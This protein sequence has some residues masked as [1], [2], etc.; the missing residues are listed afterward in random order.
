[1]KNILWIVFVLAGIVGGFL[2]GSAVT[3]RKSTVHVEVQPKPSVVKDD[4]PLADA[5]KR[6]KELERELASVRRDLAKRMKSEAKIAQKAESNDVLSSVSNSTDV[7]MVGPDG[8]ILEGLKGKLSKDE[9]SQVTNAFA[10]MRARIAQRAKGRQEYLAA[11]DV[12]G[13][14][15]NERENHS[16]FMEMLAKREAIAAKMKGGVPN[17]GAIQDMAK[18]SIE[19]EPAA[20]KERS[21]L[22]RQMARELGYSGEDVEVIHDTMK[23]IFDC[24]NAGG[25]GGIGDMIEAADA[26]GTGGIEVKAQVIGL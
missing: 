18:L 24:T 16:R 17:I 1:M 19:M 15:E 5:K 6:I 13:M 4:K 12:S 23:N 25:I 14:S 3:W 26:G 7:V 20:K 8:D 22:S 21:A 2:I 9:L 11:I 10:Q